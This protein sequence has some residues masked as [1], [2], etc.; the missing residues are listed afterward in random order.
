[1]SNT[2]YFISYFFQTGTEY[3]FGEVCITSNKR[4]CFDVLEQVRERVKTEL[5]LEEG[6]VILSAIKLEDKVDES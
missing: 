2:R 1:M 6:P 3:G 5:S 4:L